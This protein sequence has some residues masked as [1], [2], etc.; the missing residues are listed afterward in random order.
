MPVATAGIAHFSDPAA[1]ADAPLLALDE[2]K[3][4]QD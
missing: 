2:V 3:D 1:R 4:E